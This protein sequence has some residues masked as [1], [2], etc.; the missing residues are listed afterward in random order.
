MAIIKYVN[1][2]SVLIQ[3][4][5]NFILTDPWY[6]K[7]AFGS[8]LPTPP[9]SIHPAYLLALAKDNPRFSI[10]ISH[11]HDDHIDDDFLSLFPKQTRI[12]IPEY[13]SKGFMF[14]VKNKGFENVIE[15][16]MSGYQ[17]DGF[18]V[19]SYIPI[20]ICCAC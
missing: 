14:R 15:V 9:A 4:G 11:G 10:A 16:P 3:D 5:D 1:H 13:S 6:E 19:R 2:A 12:L 8:W 7:A 18:K 17:Y 20:Y